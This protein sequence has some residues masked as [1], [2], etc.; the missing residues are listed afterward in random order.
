MSTA[1]LRNIKYYVQVRGNDKLPEC[2]PQKHNNRGIDYTSKIVP[3]NRL[4][5]LESTV[6]VPS[7]LVLKHHYY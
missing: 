2:H 6:Y 4:N 1:N 5:N 3:S 7:I